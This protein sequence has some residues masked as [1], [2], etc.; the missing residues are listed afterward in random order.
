[1]SIVSCECEGSPEAFARALHPCGPG[2]SRSEP[3]GREL[4]GRARRG[5]GRGLARPA[6]RLLRAASRASGPPPTACRRGC[7]AARRAAPL[8][9][10]EP[11]ATERQ[12][13]V[14]EIG[15]AEVANGQEVDVVGTEGVGV[16]PEANLVEPP[17]KVARHDCPIGGS[18]SSVAWECLAARMVWAATGL[19]AGGSRA[20]SG[21]ASEDGEGHDQPVFRGCR[22]HRIMA[23]SDRL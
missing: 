1:M 4:R 14:L 17:L 22:Q 7:G 12:A 23:G 21:F 10:S 2:R 9:P 6:L 16:T 8:S 11:A 3:A 20:L 15:I 19:R 5:C 13:R 18:R